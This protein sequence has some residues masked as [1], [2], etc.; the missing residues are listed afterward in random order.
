MINKHWSRLQRD[1]TYV[2]KSPPVWSTVK[3]SALFSG[4]FNIV[5]LSFINGVVPCAIVLI[6]G[7]KVTFTC[8]NCVSN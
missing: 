2:K 8:I 4:D 1:T 7:F 5:E 3:G 6:T